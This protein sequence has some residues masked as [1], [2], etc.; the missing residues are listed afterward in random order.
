MPALSRL[1][2]VSVVCA[3]AVFVVAG[4]WLSSSQR[5]ASM[6]RAA[7]RRELQALSNLALNQSLRYLHTTW[8]H[9]QGFSYQTTDVAASEAHLAGVTGTQ[10]IV[11]LAP[12]GGFGAGEMPIRG[13]AM[14]AYATELAL[15]EGLYD[16]ATVTV[17]AAQARRRVVGWTNGLALSYAHD[18]W[19]HAWES[20]LWVYYLGF[21]ARQAWADLPAATRGL[22][23][24]AVASEA[25][26]LLA[27]PP[28]Y[29]RDATG[30]VV[31]P[32][33]SKAEEDAW[34]AALLFLAAREFPDEPHA[35]R[36]EEQ[37]RAYASAAWA[38]PD[39]VGSRG[40]A[41]SNIATDGT[42]TNHDRDIDPDYMLTDAEFVAK[43]NLLAREFD[44]P[45]SSETMNGFFRVW[46]GLTVPK[47]PSPPYQK[48]G[49]TIYRRG[50]GHSAT[51]QLY[52]PSGGGWSSTRSDAAALM[53]E[54]AFEA[55]ND[56][57]AADWAR[58][59]LAYVLWQQ[60][61][62]RD[63]RIFS[64]GETGYPLDEQLAAANEAELSA[65]LT[66]AP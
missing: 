3:V 53:D 54:E 49:G 34:N 7:Q 41:G 63:G 42:V 38:S 44:A 11:V 15:H 16:A 28:P 30:T 14:A 45:P 12:R 21:T 61:R 20:A 19:G 25:D 4:T 59:H 37:G 10:T 9:Q 47:F 57:K 24:S 2:I 8:W 64:A 18:G 56:P 55:R 46:W 66:S 23:R 32:G 48:P 43:M 1:R 51:S 13:Q 6:T 62:H 52:F 17:S 27:I 29:Y 65:R 36:W 5:D 22:V 31:S 50:P 33:D 39:E 58:A 40:I 60:S 35:K 26:H